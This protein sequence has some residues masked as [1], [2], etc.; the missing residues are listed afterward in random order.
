MVHK[1]WIFAFC[2]TLTALAP[3]A[4]SNAA[5]ACGTIDRTAQIQINEYRVT[6]ELAFSEQEKSCGLS[7]RDALPE[8]HGMLFLFSKE[9]S[10][11]FWMK[12]T[13]IP[14]SI[15]FL[16]EN[17]TILNILEMQ[18]M[19]SE[20]LYSSAAPARYALEMP[21]NWFADHKVKPGDGVVFDLTAVL[22]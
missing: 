7:F 17:G 13:R 21:A 9:Q 6:V 2:F 5:Q 14:L 4:G 3:L 20:T 1:F 8:D 18:P 11:T 12:D 19:D 10:L 16:G 22:N 15:A